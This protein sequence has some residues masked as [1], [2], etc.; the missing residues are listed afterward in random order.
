MIGALQDTSVKGESCSVLEKLDS[1]RLGSPC[2]TCFESSEFER[3]MCSIEFWSYLN[4]LDPNTV[5]QV[6]K[7]ERFQF[8]IGYEHQQ[9]WPFLRFQYSTAFESDCLSRHAVLCMQM[10]LALTRWQHK[11]ILERNLP[12]ALKL[13][14]AKK[15][16][17]NLF[18]KVVL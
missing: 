6:R 4:R 3:Q 13:S 1:K 17:N 14:I 5:F 9:V 7:W 18:S 16:E 2:E 12:E 8:V 15:I 10:L 11:T